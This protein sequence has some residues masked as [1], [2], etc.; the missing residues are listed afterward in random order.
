[1]RLSVDTPLP[2]SLER[3]ES[4]RKYL[5][6]GIRETVGPYHLFHQPRRA[7][8]VVDDHGGP[9]GECPAAGCV[10]RVHESDAWAEPDFA[11]QAVRKT[12]V[13]TLEW[14]LKVLLLSFC[15][16]PYSKVFNS[17]LFRFSTF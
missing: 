15:L 13:E 16:Y 3:P 17:P 10:T 1:M 4:A 9:T 2:H 8:G 14:R 12:K 7:R 11:S 6:E 5:D